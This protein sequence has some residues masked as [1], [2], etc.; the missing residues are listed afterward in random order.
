M[1]T[2]FL[3]G[4]QPLF[5]CLT[6]GVC[7]ADA[8]GKLLYANAAAGTLLGPKVA[9]LTQEAI[10]GI[11]C[12]GLEGHSC[13]EAANCPLRVPR[14][15]VHAATF[16]GRFA[17][18]GR[19]LRV[20]C[21][22]VRLPS[23][24]RHFLLVEDVTA[25]AEA[26]RQKEEWR[27]MLAHDFRSPLTIALGTLRAVED[28][29][30]GHPLAADDLALVEGGVRNCRRLEALIN[31]Y[32]D[33][34]RLEDGAMP[35]HSGTV[36]VEALIRSVV[37]EHAPAAATGGQL[38]TYNAPPTLTARADP[39]L[40]RRA[41]SN[42]LGNALKF[43]PQGGRISLDASL[44]ENIVLIR[45]TDNGP[46]IPARDLPHIF[47]RYYQ[48]DNGGRR[49]GLGL[50]L[51]FCRA[52]MRAMGGEIEAESDEGRGAVFTLRLPSAAPGGPS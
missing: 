8:D 21:M 47:D 46:G 52:A 20:R 19:D 5:D 13:D 29:G 42:I 44:L 48:G 37:E 18:T 33:T 2:D 22:R 38:L 6:D 43:T 32:L 50:G 26:G 17:P 9:A 40:L 27:Q 34:N 45:V 36:G 30:A 41:L 24:D 14:G 51:T 10:C 12:G 11:L 15:P 39:E 16:K 28:M 35:V 4:L 31:A 23:H 25:Q 1:A 3:D 49:H 7:V